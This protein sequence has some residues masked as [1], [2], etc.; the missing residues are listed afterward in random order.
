MKNASAKQV[1]TLKFCFS[2][3]VGK[4]NLIAIKHKCITLFLC[5]NFFK[6]LTNKN[7][8][9]TYVLLLETLF[10]KLVFTFFLLMLMYSF[11]NIFPTLDDNVCDTNK[12]FFLIIEMIKCINKM[13]LMT[14]L[15]IW[16][17]VPQKDKIN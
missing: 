5:S 9:Y 8:Q 16:E 7:N 6:L 4:Q 11:K 15:Y 13:I 1:F 3:Q 12:S 14:S 2:N 17:C 10:T